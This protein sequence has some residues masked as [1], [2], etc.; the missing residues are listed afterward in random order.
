MREKLYEKQG[1]GR[2]NNQDLYMFSDKYFLSKISRSLIKR[3]RQEDMPYVW[4]TTKGNRKRDVG[5]FVAVDVANLMQSTELLESHLMESNRIL[6][7]CFAS[8]VR[9]R[10]KIQNLHSLNHTNLH[11]ILMKIPYDLSSL[12]SNSSSQRQGTFLTLVHV[13]M[14]SLL[15]LGIRKNDRMSAISWTDLLAVDACRLYDMLQRDDPIG[16]ITS[17]DQIAILNKARLSQIHL[18]WDSKESF[19]QSSN[20]IKG[21]IRSRLRKRNNNSMQTTFSGFH[22]EDLG[23]AMRRFV[24]DSELKNISEMIE[25]AARKFDGINSSLVIQLK[26]VCLLLHIVDTRRKKQKSSRVKKSLE[27]YHEQKILET[28]MKHCHE[29][30]YF[31]AVSDFNGNSNTYNNS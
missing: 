16:N 26:V 20:K 19:V 7:G 15:N 28:L 2:I 25:S 21:A 5:K 27:T 9:E 14:S 11:R 1:N 29:E 23:T 18:L 10:S 8:S 12:V 3:S 24:F 31:K 30:N 4:K 6:L 22:L 13:L 17:G